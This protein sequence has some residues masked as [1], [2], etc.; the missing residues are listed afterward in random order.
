MEIDNRRKFQ[1][2]KYDGKAGLKFLNFTYD[3]YQVKNLNLTGLFIEGNFLKNKAKNCHV[4]IFHKDKQGNNSLKALAKVVWKNDEGIGLKFTSMTFENYLL[5]QTTLINN[6]E[7][8]G[9]ILRELPN[10]SPFFISNF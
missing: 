10:T 1:R 9:N 6:A 3:C 4:Q 7:E 8:S 2:I 5:L